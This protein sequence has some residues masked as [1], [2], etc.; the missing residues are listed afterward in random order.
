[1]EVNGFQTLSIQDIH[2]V[3]VEDSLSSK[4][5]IHPPG[6]RDNGELLESAVNR[7]FVSMGRDYKYPKP[8]INA[9]TLCYG[10]CSNHAFY[11]G[12]KRTA[13]VSMLCHLD[14]NNLTLKEEVSQQDLYRLMLRIASHRLTQK[15]PKGDN[16]DKEVLE[17]GNWL[18][19]RTRV[20]K[21]GEKV[22]TFRELRK[23]LRC[24][25]IHL[26]NHKGNRID[27]IKYETKRTG[28]LMQ[29]RR[30]GRRVLHIPFPKEGMDVGKKVVKSV[31]VACGL[32]TE[33]GYDADMFYGAETSIDKFI[34][35]YKQTLKRLAKT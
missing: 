7:Q 18:N 25:D 6:I 35:K 14:K 3:L 5:P 30:I 4:D 22:V 20:L 34:V 9:A 8:A 21:K 13:L 10:I 19:K 29:K 16:S 24:Y 31:R 26:E 33:D 12:N 32:T 23:I 1:M 28:I 2:D 27:V 17:I 11:N 15:K